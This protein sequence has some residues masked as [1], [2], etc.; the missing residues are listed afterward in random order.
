MASRTFYRSSIV[1]D[2]T[3][4]D[5][6]SNLVDEDHDFDSLLDSYRQHMINS[7][8]F[9]DD[10]LWWQSETSEIFWEDDGSEKPL[11]E[12]DFDDWWSKNTESW[13]CS[14]N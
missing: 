6:I 7:M 11:P 9:L 10:R 3:I 13:I 1:G 12:I 4:N 5:M 8:E 14:I 2:T